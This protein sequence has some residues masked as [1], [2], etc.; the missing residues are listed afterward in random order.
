MILHIIIIHVVL[1]E[2]T[3]DVRAKR[4]H[5]MS[6]TDSEKIVHKKKKKKNVATCM[7]GND[8]ENEETDVHVEKG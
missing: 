7:P 4:A 3:R 5:S 2:K 6:S 1:G 8:D